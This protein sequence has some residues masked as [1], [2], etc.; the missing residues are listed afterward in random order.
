M[1]QSGRTSAVKY[2]QGRASNSAMIKGERRIAPMKEKNKS[3][4]AAGLFIIRGISGT[5]GI[6]LTSLSNS[7]T[8]LAWLM[9]AENYPPAFAPRRI[10]R[11]VAVSSAVKAYRDLR[12]HLT[13][14]YSSHHPGL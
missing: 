8:S 7:S 2:I 5:A 13:H 9:N 10:V 12:A 11:K 1:Q 6:T 14:P 4:F 3:A